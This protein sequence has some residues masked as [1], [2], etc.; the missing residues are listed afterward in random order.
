MSVTGGGM[1]AAQV[2]PD[3]VNGEIWECIGTIIIRNVF[4]TFSSIEESK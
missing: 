4:I 1:P 3:L 2:N